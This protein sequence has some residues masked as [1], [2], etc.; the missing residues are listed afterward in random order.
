MKNKTSLSI[1]ENFKVRRIYDEKKEIWY[2]SVVD[3]VAILTEQFDYQTARKYWNKL[4]ERLKQEGSEVVTNCHRLKIVAQ[5][6]KMR[7]T[8]VADVET[9]L[10]LIQSIP[11][12]KAEPIKLWLAK[13]GY[14]RMQEMIDPEKA[15]N[16]SREYWQKQGRS[17]KWIQQR[18]MRQETRNKLTDYWSDHGVKKGDEFAILTN[19]IHQEWSELSV[20][21]H[22]N[23]K[24][25]KTQNLRDHMTEAELIFTALAELSTRQIADHTKAEGLEQNKVPAKK[26][27]KIAKDA[28]R[29]LEQKTGKSIVTGENFLANKKTKKTLS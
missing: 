5:D 13:V 22:K 12:K 16:R 24:G 15:L 23:L 26:G 6:S 2:F 19:I 8:D 18:M 1:F 28:R 9:L 29:A 10:R 11:S 20:K 4:S 25:L 7:E 27:G 14:E 17:T 21:D 3:I